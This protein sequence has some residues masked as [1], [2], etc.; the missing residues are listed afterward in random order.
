M[1]HFKRFL[2]FLL[3]ALQLLQTASADS[4][5]QGLGQALKTQALQSATEIWA[6]A[7]GVAAVD[8]KAERAMDPLMQKGAEA[9]VG[10]FALSD[11]AAKVSYPLGAEIYDPANTARAK[12]QLD[13]WKKFIARTKGKATLSAS[14]MQ[15]ASAAMLPFLRYYEQGT[16]QKPD[17]YGNQV[18]VPSGQTVQI[19]LQGYC[20]DRSAPAPGY[21]EKLQLVPIQK[22]IPQESIGLYQAMM[23][24]SAMH[25]EKR[26][27]IQNLVWGLRHAADP[28]PHIKTLNPSQ[29]A[30]L[31]EVLPNGAAQYQAHLSRQAAL[32]KAQA[33]NRQAFRD[34]L[35]KLRAKVNV[36]LADPS[37]AGYTPADSNTLLA[38]LS[39][40]PV[41]GVPQPNSDYTLLAPGVAAKT[42]AYGVNQVT[43]EIRNIGPQPF[44]FDANA[45]AGQSTR[46]TQRVAFGGILDRSQNDHRSI[47]QRFHD[48]MQ[49]LEIP[50]LKHLQA[51]IQKTIDTAADQPG[52]SSLKF[53]GLALAT[54]MNQ[55]LLPTTVLDVALLPESKLLGAAEKVT[56]TEISALEKA[57]DDLAK[58][59]T[60]AID[61]ATID[62][63]LAIPKGAR[64]DPSTYLSMDAIEAH[65]SNFDNGAAY[66]VPKDALDRYGRDLLGRPDNTQ[67]VM[68]KTEMDQML[69][70]ANGNV[71][72]LENELGIP[73]GAWQGKDLVRIDIPNPRALDLRMPSGNEMGANNLWIP[74]GRLPTG[75]LEAVV[76]AIPKGQYTENALW[77]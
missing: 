41:E 73:A 75:Q 46:V 76:N 1:A 29:I 71:A 68:T 18:T 9:A 49:L 30:L 34:S 64:P 42:A 37:A 22:L 62:R 57:A 74:G 32:G 69:A 13:R 19:K 6:N 23:Q 8:P 50:A 15:E 20:M 11:K 44:V 33:A 21:A 63:I 43:V 72:T 14:E 7:A 28:E 52:G 39:R 65:L 60:K 66:I 25:V 16:G 35:N 77:R 53:A 24:F 38:A 67:F 61:Q 26:S 55:V 12:K 3:I 36:P 40:M 70:R 27:E 54:A 2:A 47:L 59:S 4:F 17:Y 48:V 5:L 56:A 31:N 51:Q 10:V 45:Y 58:A